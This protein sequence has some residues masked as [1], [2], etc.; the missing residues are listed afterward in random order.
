[1]CHRPFASNSSEIGSLLPFC[2]TWGKDASHNDGHATAPSEG[3]HMS[4]GS[5]DAGVRGRLAAQMSE[6]AVN[7]AGPP[8]VLLIVEDDADLRVLAMMELESLG[9]TVI[10]AADG[11]EALD[12]LRAHAIDV[13]VIDIRMPRM[14]G[15]ALLAAMQADEVLSR[16]PVIV[17]TAY[18][19]GDGLVETLALGAQDYLEKP[20]PPQELCAR[21][22]VALR[23][24]RLEDALRAQNAEM[25]A[26]VVRRQRLETELR[27]AEERFRVAFENAPIGMALAD[28]GAEAPGRLLKVN[29]ALMSLTGRS[30]GELLAGALRDVVV[31]EDRSVHD[32][33]I[34]A[35]EAGAVLSDRTEERIV[36]PSGEIRWA[37]RS[38][39]LAT[40]DD[41][42]PMYL[43]H[44]IQDVTERRL[45][46]ERLSHRALYD[47]LTSLPNRGLFMDRLTLALGRAQRERTGVAVLFCDLDSF[48]VINDS[49]GHDVGDQLL[50][51]MAERISLAL[52]PND[53]AA[54][55][56]GDEFVVLCDGI[57]SEEEAVSIADRLAGVISQPIKVGGTE[58]HV[59][60]SIGIARTFSDSAHA[61][62]L[63]RDADMAMYK[64]K[65]S[66]KARSALC[67]DALR[68]SAIERLHVENAL[69]GGI[70]ADELRLY[71]QPIVDIA[72]GRISGVEAL[73]R[74]QRPGHGLI[75]PAGFLDIAEDSR[76]IVE[77][78][79][80]VLRT[81]CEQ[82]AAWATRFPDRPPLRMAVNLSGHQLDRSDL[83]DTVLEA[84]AESGA[85]PT[86]LCL[87]V[88]ESVL[89]DA[90]SSTLDDLRRLKEVGVKLA[91]DDF[92]TGFSSLTYLKRFPI[93]VIKID[94]SFVGGLGLSSED[95]AIVDAV[96]ALGSGLHL[97]TVAE[98][99]ET[100]LQLDELRKRGC[101]SAQGFLFSRAASAADVTRLLE[102][103]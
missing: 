80:W 49:L 1:M 28:V 32:R 14:D 97:T 69:R 58:L 9:H 7:V 34:A 35:L 87:E 98:G 29:V 5:W 48:K 60:A 39:S 53:S 45:F 17:V 22:A 64:A 102:S 76:L 21:V 86:S 92:G 81:A 75:E 78:G 99:V 46:E 11:L 85:D 38:T 77:M 43:V 73:L 63:L 25:A 51:A 12:Q 37:L 96:L 10:G 101:V 93:D 59:T 6:H 66:G 79:R 74:W 2:F 42:R 68:D 19:G 90:T 3:L 72:T 27:T 95:D 41:G 18:G 67:D 94:S 44:Q 55:I 100:A 40:G 65:R 15:R 8:G 89:V 24:R 13:A 52:R 36:H 71:Y 57:D 56:G 50:V 82:S 91:I 23:T 70:D 16:V 30:E 4:Q 54:R 20:Y 84:L 83:A 103:A 26:D 31:P 61:A 33:G 62:A 88:T 47:S